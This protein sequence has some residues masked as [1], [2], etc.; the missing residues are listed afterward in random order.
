MQGKRCSHQIWSRGSSGSLT[1]WP[2][3]AQQ[4]RGRAP[5]SRSPPIFLLKRHFINNSAELSD[6]SSRGRSD[7]FR[8]QELAKERTQTRRLGAGQVNER[9]LLVPCLSD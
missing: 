7:L 6:N 2:M 3:P 9:G 4:S 8:A 1:E 5:W